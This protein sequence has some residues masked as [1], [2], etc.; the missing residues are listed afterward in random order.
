M[1]W[2]WLLVLR[3]LER[4]QGS[5]HQPAD[6]LGLSLPGSPAEKGVFRFYE[7]HQLQ[8]LGAGLGWQ[9]RSG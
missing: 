3:R 1:P 4:P 7:G 2:V 6:P 8:V 5:A 9:T